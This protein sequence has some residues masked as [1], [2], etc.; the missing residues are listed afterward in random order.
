MYQGILIR[1][2]HNWFQIYNCNNIIKYNLRYY[3]PWLWIYISGIDISTY[4][5]SFVSHLAVRIHQPAVERNAYFEMSCPNN[6]NSSYKTLLLHINIG[7]QVEYLMVLTNVL[8]FALRTK[9]AHIRLI[10]KC[11]Q[12]LCIFC[13]HCTAPL[14]WYMIL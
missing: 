13:V 14:H 9:V 4:E 6:C 12:C 10:Y 7:N 3:L 8:S 5:Q 11:S 1:R 2:S